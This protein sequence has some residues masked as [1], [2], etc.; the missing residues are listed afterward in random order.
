MGE[1]P[2]AVESCRETLANHGAM[3]SWAGRHRIMDTMLKDARQLQRDA[4]TKRQDESPGAM[5]RLTDNGYRE[6][7]WG[8]LQPIGIGESWAGTPAADMIPGKSC[9][10]PA[11]IPGP[12]NERETPAAPGAME[13]RRLLPAVTVYTPTGGQDAQKKET[14]LEA[15]RSP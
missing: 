6:T 9:R 12:W 14:A 13:R 1:T 15:P 8:Y 4:R 3:E 2:D 10:A 11:A 7:M 5:E